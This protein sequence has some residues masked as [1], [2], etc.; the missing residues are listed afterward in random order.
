MKRLILASASPRRREIL[1]VLG[2]P[3]TVEP[4]GIDE[5]PR[6][7]E[8]PEDFVRRAA[9]EKGIE[10]SSRI[11]DNAVILSADTIVVVDGEILGKPR[12]LDDARRMLRRL[13][14]REHAVLTAVWVGD[15]A[16]NI[17]REGMERT[18]VWFREL[19]EEQIGDYVTRE[20]VL[21]KAGAYAIQGYAAAYIPRIEGNYFNVMG[22][23]LP[24][25]VD[26]LR[27][28]LE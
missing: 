27:Q 21:D 3:F 22:L 19:S 2:I 5:I 17:N 25:V 26:F 11:G 15:H 9:R 12:D 13:S 28:A 24:L 1:S 16:R 4:A 6:D 18:A 14:G 7:G 10:V 23:P 8:S 20:D